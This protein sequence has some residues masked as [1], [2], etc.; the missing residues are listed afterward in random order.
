M[1]SN[2]PEYLSCLQH[3]SRSKILNIFNTK[4]LENEGG[5]NHRFLELIRLDASHKEGITLL[6]GCHQ[7]VQGLLELRG[8]SY[9]FPLVAVFPQALNVLS[10]QRL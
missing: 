10:K 3:S 1:V 9:H 7:Q 5:N 4:L 6:Q 8:Q 2:I